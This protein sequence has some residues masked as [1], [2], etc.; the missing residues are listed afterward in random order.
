MSA[1]VAVLMAAYNAEKT[2]LAAVES[3]L[4]STVPCDSIWSTTAAGFRSSR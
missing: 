1:D 4:A 2:L 3:I